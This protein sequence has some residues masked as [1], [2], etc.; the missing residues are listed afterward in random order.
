MRCEEFEERLN[1]VLDERRRPEWDPE[2][3]SHSERCPACRHVAALYDVLLDGFYAL[4]AP[5]APADMS[6]R[7]LAESRPSPARWRRVVAAGGALAAAAAVL[8]VVGPLLVSEPEAAKQASA[9]A[10]PH[11]AARAQSGKAPLEQLPLPQFFLVE[12]QRG[13]PY[14]GL[15]KGTGQSLATVIRYVPGVTGSRGI[16]DAEE[17]PADEPAWA[18][19]MSEGL[20]PLTDSVTETVNLLLEALPVSQFASRS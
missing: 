14:V 12:S 16:I 1:A 13:D 17:R 15:A 7:V 3:R 9:T 5:E 19:R 2:L 18:V 8:I 6:L 10:A 11:A 20:K 4:A